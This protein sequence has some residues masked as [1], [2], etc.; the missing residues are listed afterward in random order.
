MT[1]FKRMAAIACLIAPAPLV[2]Q[3]DGLVLCLPTGQDA[4]DMRKVAGSVY[5][6]SSLE[7]LGIEAAHIP[8]PFA[9]FPGA[10]SV[11]V[12]DGVA[13]HDRDIDM[14]VPTMQ[15]GITGRRFMTWQ[16]QGS[17]T[18]RLMI[19]EPACAH[20]TAAPEFT[21]SCLDPNAIQSA[22]SD[23]ASF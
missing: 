8:L 13:F 19:E 11:G 23:G 16:A 2:A 12:V 14:T 3:T 18:C 5:A 17:V 9:E 7:K 4:A 20:A 15:M 10:L 6:I 1:Y 22:T 21:V